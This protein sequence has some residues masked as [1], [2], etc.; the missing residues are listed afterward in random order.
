MLLKGRLSESGMEIYTVQNKKW[1]AKVM[2]SEL[3][4]PVLGMRPLEGTSRHSR[5]FALDQI[6]SFLARKKL[7]SKKNVGK[8]SCSFA[9]DESHISIVRGYGLLGW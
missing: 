2:R 7:C 6:E 5:S 3:L 4:H 9:I 8:L 1:A